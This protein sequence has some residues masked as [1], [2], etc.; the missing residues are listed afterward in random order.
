MTDLDDGSLLFE[1]TA[2]GLLEMAWHLVLWR[3]A[4]EVLGPPEFRDMLE[5]VQRGEVDILP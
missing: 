3:N 4:V 5:Q 2:S 1:F